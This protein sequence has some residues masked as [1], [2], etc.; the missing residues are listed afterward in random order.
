MDI[1]KISLD[2]D[3]STATDLSAYSSSIYVNVGIP[4]VKY[5]ALSVLGHQGDID[6]TSAYNGEVFYEPRECT[7]IIMS[8]SGA[9][10]TASSVASALIDAYLGQ[11]VRL[12][13]ITQDYMLIGRLTEAEYEE[14]SNG[15]DYKIRFKLIAEP[16]RYETTETEHGDI[17]PIST[18]SNQWATLTANKEHATSTGFS[19]N[20]GESPLIQ[21]SV[22][23]NSNQYYR[24][25]FSNLSNCTVRVQNH[26]T[27]GEFKYMLVD[28]SLPFIPKYDTLMVVVE[29]ID[30]E[31][32]V[33][34]SVY[35]GVYPATVIDYSGKPVAIKVAQIIS[36]AHND[37]YLLNNGVGAK[38]DYGSTFK[39]YPQLMLSTGANKLLVMASAL[40]FDAS[41]LDSTSW[42]TIKW[43][44]G[45]L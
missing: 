37:L 20:A 22:T 9:D 13:N 36:D 17:M 27:F 2:Q 33:S 43:R 35:V 26:T 16:W 41:T 18:P 11:R 38:L 3:G 15:K 24:I 40:D 12:Q 5:N 21:F 32:P 4:K 8:N 39:E 25:V 28:Y 44:E 1:W 7:V 29:P 10:I 31:K 6:M 34:G 42:I 45:N 19:A 30:E 23:P 14:L